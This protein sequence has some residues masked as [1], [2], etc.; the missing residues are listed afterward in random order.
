VVLQHSTGAATFK[1]KARLWQ[2]GNSVAAPMIVLD[3]T[4]QTLVAQT[5]SAKSP[6]Q[7]VIVSATRSVPVAVGSQK[8][9]EPSM[10]SV[11]GGDLK[12]SSAERKAV[13]RA[14]VAGRVVSSTVD[15]TTVSNELEL[16]LL[17]PGNHAGK[18]GTAGQ[19]D[20]MTSSGHVE[21][22]AGSRSGTGEQLVYTSESGNYVLTGTAA[23]PPRF[24]DQT[25]GTV[26]GQALIF[27]SRDDSVS[28]EGD[29]RKTT[30]ITTAPK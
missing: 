14:G 19:V 20:R 26:T 4:K 28:I 2:E 12:Y 29:G 24:T 5:D 10:I 8:Q 6:V 23:S 22:S 18:E 13:M 16:I 30:T 11:R 7:V 21:I 27:N 9:K 3:R 1:G 15:A 17:P 25:R